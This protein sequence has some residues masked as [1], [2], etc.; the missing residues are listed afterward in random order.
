MR[1]RRLRHVHAERER[2]A[3]R[4]PASWTDEPQAFAM[5]QHVGGM[6]RRSASANH[7]GFS[8]NSPQQQPLLP[9]GEKKTASNQSP[10]DPSWTREP[11]VP[12]PVH[13][14]LS[15][16]SGSTGTGSGGSGLKRIDHDAQQGGPHDTQ[17]APAAAQV[18]RSVFGRRDTT[19]TMLASISLSA[20][21]R[22]RSE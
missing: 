1:K 9:Y 15:T 21:S 7:A 13:A 2:Q 17:L 8:L 10:M 16:A 5:R 4:Q 12:L 19:W 20:S 14:T 6:L 11:L 18:R 3:L 22:I